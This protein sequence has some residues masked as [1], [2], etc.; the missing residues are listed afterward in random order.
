MRTIIPVFGVSYF[1]IIF[2]RKTMVTFILS[3]ALLALGYVF[4]GKRV[5]RIFGSDD[6]ATPVITLNDGVDFVPKFSWFSC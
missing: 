1:G 3:I 6:R 4:Y 5:D 2:R